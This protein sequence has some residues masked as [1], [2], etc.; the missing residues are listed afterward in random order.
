MAWFVLHCSIASGQFQ[1]D[2]C[3]DPARIVFRFLHACPT[4]LYFLAS[5]P[6]PAWL[7]D[8]RILNSPLAVKKIGRIDRDE[9]PLMA[10]AFSNPA[11]RVHLRSKTKSIN[12]TIKNKTIPRSVQAITAPIS[13]AVRNWAC[14]AFMIV[15]SPS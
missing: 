12:C 8:G 11:T 4:T 1:W 5:P 9:E 7:D 15:P 3:Y 6:Q 13:S 10:Y 2:R 14:M